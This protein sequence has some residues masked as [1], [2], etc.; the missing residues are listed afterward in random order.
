MGGVTHA[1]QDVG[2]NRGEKRGAGSPTSGKME[3][4]S[5]RQEVT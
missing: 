4:A 1:A 2:G 5:G 3:P